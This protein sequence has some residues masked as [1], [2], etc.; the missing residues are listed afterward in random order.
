MF[1]PSL[2][3]FPLS[4]PIQMVHDKHLLDSL[5]EEDLPKTKKARRRKIRTCLPMYWES[6]SVI[7][8]YYREDCEFY[9]QIN[10]NTCTTYAE[11]TEFPGS[12]KE[13]RSSLVR[14]GN[15]ASLEDILYYQY[16]NK[17]IKKWSEE[18]IYW[19]RIF[20]T[21]LGIK[22]EHT[23]MFLGRTL[24]SVKRKCID[25]EYTMGEVI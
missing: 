23:A 1:S 21:K 2:P 13:W 24:A 22:L 20:R 25:I 3:S 9:A 16:G 5:Y 8:F 10:I 19:L 11:Y 12:K 17:R 15:L 6:N 14:T 7:T 4:W 18:E